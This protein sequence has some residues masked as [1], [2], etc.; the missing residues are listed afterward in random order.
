VLGEAANSV[1]GHVAGLPVGKNAHAMLHQPQRA[2]VLL[3]TEPELDCADPHAALGALRKAE[4]VVALSAFRHDGDANTRTCCCRSRRSPRLRHVRLDRGQGTELP[5]A[6]RPIGES[7]PAWKVLRVLGE[8]L[9]LPGFDYD[10]IERVRADCL[11][12]RT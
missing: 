4:F 3:N 6:V 9:G 11:A 5:S 12:A 10:T 2:Y 8:M 1:G 7:R